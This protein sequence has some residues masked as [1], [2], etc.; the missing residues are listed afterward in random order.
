MPPETVPSTSDMSEASPHSPSSSITVGRDDVGDIE[1][2]HRSDSS[3]E[4]IECESGDLDLFIA[5]AATLEAFGQERHSMTCQ[6]L[7]EAQ[8]AQASP[9]WSGKQRHMD[10]IELEEAGNTVFY[11]VLHTKTTPLQAITGCKV[12][13][14]DAIINEGIQLRKTKMATITNLW[15]REEYRMNGMAGSL[16]EGVKGWLD[17]AHEDVQV[18]LSVIYSTMPFLTFTKSG[19]KK[20]ITEQ[21]RIRLVKKGIL[22]HDSSQCQ[23]FQSRDLENWAQHD[24]DASQLRLTGRREDRRIRIQ[25]SPTSDLL[26]VRMAHSLEQIHGLG[27]GLCINIGAYCVLQDTRNAWAWML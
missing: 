5:P 16:L 14:K 23:Y 1:D 4:P 11:C 9:F 7:R 6:Y 2:S 18:E 13:I 27:K 26:I 3:D 21:L 8:L 22:V 25:I 17:F 12:L 19:W 10:R 20:Q 24:T 15:T